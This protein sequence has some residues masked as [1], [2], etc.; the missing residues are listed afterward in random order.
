MAVIREDRPAPGAK[1]LAT[2]GALGPRRA[3]PR[4]A[5]PIS[6]SAL[7]V[8]TLAKR[9][10]LLAYELARPYQTRDREYGKYLNDAVNLYRGRAMAG[11]QT[12]QAKKVSKTA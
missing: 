10:A 9:P 12:R 5:A 6:D 7:Y 8:A 4:R 2:N 11:V 3:S 1:V